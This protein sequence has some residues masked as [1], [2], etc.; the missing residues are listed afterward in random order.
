MF[1]K[2]SNGLR[3]AFLAVAVMLFG[4]IP[5]LAH[6]GPSHTDAPA[7]AVWT[8]I[9]PGETQWF[10]FRSEGEGDDILVTLHAASEGN[11]IGALSFKIF[12][13][14]NLREWMDGLEVNP[15]GRGSKD[16]SLD[17]DLVWQGNFVQAGTYHIIVENTASTP[18]A[19]VLEASGD[20]IWF[21]SSGAASQMTA[22]A[23]APSTE[24]A[25]TV[26]MDLSVSGG[27]GPENALSPQGQWM[28]LPAQSS[29]W[30]AFDSRGEN[31]AILAQLRADPAERF[32]FR[33]LTPQQVRE[34]ADGLE[35]HPV[36][37]GSENE[38]LSS[39]LSWKGNFNT[40]GRYFIIVENSA[41]APGSF[42][43]EVAGDDISL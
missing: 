40:A 2:W 8:D 30:F 14:Q 11:G 25:M 41:S 35:V 36:G 31:E 23:E 29:L 1:A 6:D 22:M 26:S 43:L 38:I 3:L 10:S 42:S 19:Y 37:Q 16:A 5:V 24:T 33:V 27:T 17:D 15:V 39:D 18:D 32:S 13:A 12:T 9:G 28:Q 7:G 21:E 20:D 34:W 4:A